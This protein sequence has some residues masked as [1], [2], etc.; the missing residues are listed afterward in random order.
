MKADWIT[1]EKCTGCGACANICPSGAITVQEDEYGFYRPEIDADKCTRC[2]ACRRVCS[3]RGGFRAN[4][5][6]CRVFAAHTKDE[7]VREDST[8]GGIFTELAKAVFSD[9]G[10]VVGAIYG[11]DMRVMHAVADDEEGLA[12]LRRSKYV[13]SFSGDIYKQVK[14]RLES[15]KKV[16]FC[17]TPCQAAALRSYL[18]RDYE[19]LYIADIVCRGVNSPR[20]FSAWLKEIEGKEGKKVSGIG[21]RDKSDGWKASSYRTRVDFADGSSKVF[22]KDENA[23]IDGFLLYNMYMRQSCADCDFKGIPRP[24]DITLGDFW[25]AD[26]RYDDD[27]GTSLITINTARGMELF[28]RISDDIMC[29]EVPMDGAFAENP[30]FSNSVVINRKSRRFLKALGGGEFTPLLRKYSK[31]NFVER[32]AG[33]LRRILRL[34]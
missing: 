34:R 5:Y 12:A 32:A 24:G 30:C 20:A 13:Q 15:G 26:S 1:E 18:G 14:E 22:R 11:R 23:F 8:S 4:K 7:A 6:G 31:R 9:G 27:R 19:N 21:F 25:G 28:S 29:E 17:G 16:L 2:G 33:R 10:C 3:G